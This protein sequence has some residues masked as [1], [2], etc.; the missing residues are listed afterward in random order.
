MSQKTVFISYRRKNGSSTLAQLLR[1]FLTDRGYE[2]FVD[3]PSVGPGRW[4]QQILS[5]VPYSAHFLLLLTP[6]ALKS[7][8]EPGNWV[9]REFEL[10]LKT[11]R[12]IVPICEEGLDLD[13][14]KATCPEAMTR[15]FDFQVVTLRPGQDSDLEDLVNT[16]IPPH[17]APQGAP[18]A[19]RRSS[20][21]RLKHSTPKL[22]GRDDRL[23]ALEAAWA[24]PATHVVTVV[25]WGGVGKTA[26]VGTWTAQLAARDFDG[27]DYFDWSFYSQGTREQGSSSADQFIDA[28]L[29]FFGDEVMAD[30]T[31]SPWDKGSRLAEL[32]AARRTL[33]VLDGLEP[34]QH[35]DTLRGELKDEA[36]R[37]LLRGLAMR[38]PGL[39][40]V[41]TRES[42]ED[43]ASFRANTAPE[44]KLEH[45]S[46]DAGVALL[47]TLGVVGPRGELEELV[48][49]VHGHALTLNLL[50]RFLHEAFGSDVRQRDRVDFSAVDEGGHAFRVM[51]AYERWFE[52]EGE[53]GARQLAI[54][55]LLG[56]FDRPASA[57]CLAALRQPPAIAG[58]TEALVP[59]P[60]W[61]W[62]QSVT[63]LQKAALLVRD[64]DALDAHPLVREHFARRLQEEH[65][66]AWT[67]AHGR[68]FDH[69]KD[70][71]EYRP[72]TL[73]G[74][75]PLYQAVVHGC[76]ADRHEEARDDIYN[77]RILR[78]TGKG[79]FYSLKKLGAF[80]ADLGAVAC[81]FDEPWS[82]V[83]SSLT[84]ADKAWMLAVAA[85]NLRALGRLRESVQPMQAALL[86]AIDQKK[87]KTAA[88]QASNLSEL[89]L[90]LGDVAA[91]VRD[92]KQ[93]V[94]FADR[95]GG[96][97]ERMSSRGKLANTLH[98]AGQRDKAL[99]QFRE[100][101]AMQAERQPQYPLLNSIGSFLY[102]DLL[103]ADAERAAAGAGRNVQRLS[104]ALR[105]VEQ[106]PLKMFEWRAP[107]S[108]VLD[109]A[110]DNLTL[111][112]IRLY[113]SVLDGT[114]PNAA[115]PEIEQAVSGLRSAGTLHRQPPGLL[116]RAWLRFA[117]NRPDAARADLNEAEQIARRGPMPLFL[118][119][120]ALYRAR[121]F[122]DRAALTEARRLIDKHGYGRRIEE[123]EALEAAADR[124]PE[125]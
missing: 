32:V 109:I 124:W 125:S 5:K 41:T 116:T 111:G 16:Y 123:V 104:E 49:E 42:V 39:C 64:G 82:R 14:M 29:R 62:D 1:I 37:A 89:E 11:G 75:Q 34:L 77:D 45:L 83:S 30:S 100:A 117:Q 70:N 107:N 122:H 66:D 12:N 87:W 103:L 118:A 110:L 84:E 102:C 51:E 81:F 52:A 88:V 23:E 50:G 27:A 112:R 60:E 74:L 21:S 97:F 86:M 18:K 19:P 55:R 38:N 25:A 115:K 2:T 56:L 85:F 121:F 78:D 8:N 96:E 54:L 65:P 22:F 113:R 46:T 53:A 114:P 13:A 28:A 43:L 35:S 119:D 17:A 31:R 94:D 79:G 6:G 63:R 76:R 98:H 73:D 93:S 33:L 24:D 59:L 3:I 15:L 101:E 105:E 80:G 7:C 92:A 40:V 71:T 9:R 99:Q 67:K 10:A 91:A 20:S 47:E 90:I 48:D 61:K 120:I 68:L 26:L 58:L 106:R 36:M 57:E 69:L 72:D 95:S 4:E 108:S 44:W